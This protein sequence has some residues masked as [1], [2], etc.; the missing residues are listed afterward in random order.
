MYAY[1]RHPAVFQQIPTSK[2]ESP[3]R[4][5][6][7]LKNLLSKNSQGTFGNTETIL[8]NFFWL[9][10]TWALRC[11]LLAWFS[12]NHPSNSLARVFTV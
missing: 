7:T 9:R 6:W 5:Q 4:P 2:F 1:N 10:N 8:W 12:I 3:L 11:L